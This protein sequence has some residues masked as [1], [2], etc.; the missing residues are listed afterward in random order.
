MAIFNSYVSLPEGK[1]PFSY[2]F[3]MVFLWFSH[4]F[5]MK[6]SIFVP[7]PTTSRASSNQRGSQI[8]SYA[9]PTASSPSQTPRAFHDGFPGENGRFYLENTGENPSKTIGKPPK[10]VLGKI[11]VLSGFCGLAYKFIYNLLYIYVIYNI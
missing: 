2:G 1:P 11:L 5:P 3:P 6:T 4:G 10:K 7:T 9:R 8:S